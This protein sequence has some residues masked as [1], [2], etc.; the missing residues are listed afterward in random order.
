MAMKGAPPIIGVARSRS[1]V[2]L[3]MWRQLLFE[4]VHFCCMVGGKKQ[5]KQ[6][7]MNNS[8]CTAHVGAGRGAAGRIT[9]LRLRS[10]ASGGFFVPNARGVEVRAGIRRSHLPS[11][12]TWN[13]SEWKSESLLD[14]VHTCVCVWVEVSHTWFHCVVRH[15]HFWGSDSVSTESLGDVVELQTPPS[16]HPNLTVPSVV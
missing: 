9:T 13:I 10:K 16:N 14:D 4:P 1:H 8:L 11:H 5:K 12:P 7:T 3:T 15:S 6:K 2:E